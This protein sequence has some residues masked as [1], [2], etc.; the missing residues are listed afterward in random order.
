MSV[1]LWVRG[2]RVSESIGSR[3]EEDGRGMRE[4]EKMTVEKRRERERRGMTDQVVKGRGKW[5]RKMRRQHE[6][7]MR[8]CVLI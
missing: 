4:R 8:V 7:E 3:E 2:E 1:G 6:R 5:E